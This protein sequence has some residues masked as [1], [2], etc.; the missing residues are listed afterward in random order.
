MSASVQVVCPFCESKN[1]VLSE[2][3]GAGA[4]CGR[5]RKPLFSGAPLELSAQN[6]ERHVND[7]DLPVLVDFWAPWC[8]PCRMMAPVIASAAPRLEP[9]VRVA[10]LDTEA[11]PGLASRFAIRSIPTLAV[12]HRGRILRQRSGA[13]DLS[14]LLDWVRGVVAGAES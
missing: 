12:F 10:K 3:L 7:S 5:C 4:V 13:M 8:G 6:F 11:E 14:S 1:R 2:R 9:F